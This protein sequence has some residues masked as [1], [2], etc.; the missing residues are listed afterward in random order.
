MH[1]VEAVAPVQEVRGG[2]GGAADSRELRHPVG[3]DP[4]LVER[5]EEWATDGVVA[6]ALAEGRG[7]SLVVGLGEADAVHFLRGRGFFDYR[8]RL[9]HQALP[10]FIEG[11]RIPALARG[12]ARLRSGRR[13][14]A[15]CS[16]GRSG[17][18]LPGLR[19]RASTRARDARAGAF[20]RR[21]SVR[22]GR[23]AGGARRR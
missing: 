15:R 22:R 14:G 8:S 6:A 7:L 13:W 17:A 21:G 2:F 16:G 23:G 9:S 10:I 4:V 12:S 1:R 20:A 18:F 5:L 3:P 19:A 11:S